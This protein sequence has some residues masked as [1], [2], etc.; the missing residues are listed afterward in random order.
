MKENLK[1]IRFQL[2]VIDKVVLDAIFSTCV[3]Y[4]KTNCYSTWCQWKWWIFTSPLCSS[5][6]IHHYSSPPLQW[7]IIL[8]KIQLV[9][10]YQSCILIGWATTG[11]Y[12][13]N[14][15]VAKSAGFENQNNGHWITF[16]RCF[17]QVLYVFDQLRWILLKQ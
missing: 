7:I 3:V 6:N 12:V 15:L 10:Y 14:P 16:G 9:I 13:I 1:S 4:N 11:L 2:I 8:S 17:G 5:A